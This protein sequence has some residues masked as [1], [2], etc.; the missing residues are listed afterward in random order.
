MKTLTVREVPDEVYAVICKE[1][2]TNQRSIQ[3]QVRQILAKEAL[4][5]QG[6]FGAAA[7][8]WR[9]KLAGRELGDAVKDIREARARR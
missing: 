1:A 4:L 8:Q 2:A 5:R 9:T 7:R 6:G 3:E